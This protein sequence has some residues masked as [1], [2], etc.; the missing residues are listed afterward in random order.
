MRDCAGPCSPGGYPACQKPIMTEHMVQHPKATV[1]WA[2]HG[3]ERAV[4][5]LGDGAA[6]R[7]VRDQLHQLILAIERDAST[8]DI[9]HGWYPARLDAP[10]ATSDPRR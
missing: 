2:M 10:G 7:R 6:E 1:G 4:R 5:G 9:Q 3:L 8:A